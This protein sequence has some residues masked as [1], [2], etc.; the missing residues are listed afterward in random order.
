MLLTGSQSLSGRI[1]DASLLLNSLNNDTIWGE[2][3]FTSSS[4]NEL[5]EGFDSQDSIAGRRREGNER[6]HKQTNRNKD[7]TRA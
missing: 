5:E 7:R 6:V 1:K 4:L 3:G 2:E